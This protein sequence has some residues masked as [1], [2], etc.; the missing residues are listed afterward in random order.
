MHNS[1]S[2]PTNSE[3][4]HDEEAEKEQ[5]TSIQRKRGGEEGW[6]SEQQLIQKHHHVAFSGTQL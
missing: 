6:K 5:V 1:V 4:L 3:H 2:G